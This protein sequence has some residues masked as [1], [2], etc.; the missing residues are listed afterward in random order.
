MTFV[1]TNNNN[2]PDITD[3]T[4]EIIQWQA[5]KPGGV[6]ITFDNSLNRVRYGGQGTA[7]GF[8]GTFVFCDERGQE[9]ARALIMNP[10]G[11]MRGSYDPEE[12]GIV[13]G[14]VNANVECS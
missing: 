7:L 4:E 11:S 1:D 14:L 12:D 5:K 6:D 3:P 10:V 2:V 8:Q 9:E 13:N